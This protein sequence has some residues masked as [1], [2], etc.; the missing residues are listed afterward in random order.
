MGV[1][2]RENI[3]DILIIMKHKT[4]QGKTKIHSACQRPVCDKFYWVTL[5]DFMINGISSNLRKVKLSLNNLEEANFSNQCLEDE[6]SLWKKWLIHLCF[7]NA[8]LV[9]F[10]HKKEIKT[11][12]WLY[13]TYVLLGMHTFKDLDPVSCCIW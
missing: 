4:K 1:P 9:E 5:L 13:I 12:I 8:V 7:M 2:S 11:S 6:K 3:T 10:Q